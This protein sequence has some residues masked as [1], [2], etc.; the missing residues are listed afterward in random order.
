MHMLIHTT[1]QHIAARGVDYL[2]EAAEIRPAGAAANA[3]NAAVADGDPSVVVDTI[4]L[5]HGQHGAAVEDRR[6]HLTPAR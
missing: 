1:W 5:V 3:G 6:T 2:V 4:R